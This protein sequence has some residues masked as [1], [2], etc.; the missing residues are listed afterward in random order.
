MKMMNMK[1]MG[2]MVEKIEKHK[3]VMPREFA[4]QR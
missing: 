4:G 2:M 3:V 1:D